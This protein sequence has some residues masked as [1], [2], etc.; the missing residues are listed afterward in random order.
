MAHSVAKF[1]GEADIQCKH[2]RSNMRHRSGVCDSWRSSYL[3]VT[4]RIERDTDIV[5]E[6][7]TSKNDMVRT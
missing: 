3:T 6:R 5:F 2:V 4:P 7:Q 1:D